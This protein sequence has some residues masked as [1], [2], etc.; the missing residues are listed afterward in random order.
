M[1]RTAI[2]SECG[3]YRHSL[4]REW[5]EGPLLPFSMLQ[6]SM[7]GFEIDDPTIRRCMGFARR[8]GFAGLIVVNMFG[9]I[10]PYPETLKTSVDPFGPGNY[11]EHV[12]VLE[13]AAA[14]SIPI[15]CAWGA[16]PMALEPARAFVQHADYHRARLVCLGKTKG[17]APRH[18]LYVRADQPF[19][20]F[21]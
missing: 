2:F 13:I 15:V 21:P 12:R 4:T 1:R 5:G 7:A 10:S 11:R 6:P 16:H 20:A 8:E 3:L 19:E 14:S 9:L 18:P 17:G